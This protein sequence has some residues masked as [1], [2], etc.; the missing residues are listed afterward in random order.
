MAGPQSISTEERK[1]LYV[2]ALGELCNLVHQYLAHYVWLHHQDHGNFAQMEGR[3]RAVFLVH[4][5]KKPE[6]ISAIGKSIADIR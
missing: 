1:V 4:A 6:T 2:I 5:G 3:H